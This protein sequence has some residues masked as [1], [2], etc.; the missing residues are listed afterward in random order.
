MSEPLQTRLHTPARPQSPA[1]PH[2]E[3]LITRAPAAPKRQA[4]HPTDVRQR[5]GPDPG[6]WARRRH[7]VREARPGASGSSAYLSRGSTGTRGGPRPLLQSGLGGFESAGVDK[8]K[9][10]A[11]HGQREAQHHSERARGDTPGWTQSRWSARRGPGRAPPRWTWSRWSP[12]GGPG[13]MTW[14]GRDRGGH[15]E[16]AREDIPGWT[17]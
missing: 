11:T 5:E 7:L 12:R 10:A 17:W 16:R 6:L 15:Q 8:K 9:S 13:G 14:D 1:L 3:S 2:P 4:G